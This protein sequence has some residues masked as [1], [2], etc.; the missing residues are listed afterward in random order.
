MF[1]WQSSLARITKLDYV[2]YTLIVNHRVFFFVSPFFFLQNKSEEL[3]KH[4]MNWVSHV[5][6]CYLAP[7]VS[8]IFIL[9]C[10]DL[11]RLKNFLVNTFFCV[12]SRWHQLYHRALISSQ[13][14]LQQF[15][16]NLFLF[17]SFKSLCIFGRCFSS[18]KLMHW[19]NIL[20]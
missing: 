19:L 1:W 6:C 16:F 13:I 2:Q 3:Q 17:I 8:F 20:R 9:S 4:W 12:S 18:Y 5:L 10:S 7:F 15:A 11:K 14:P